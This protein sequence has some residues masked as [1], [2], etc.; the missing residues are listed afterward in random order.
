MAVMILKVRYDVM[1]YIDVARKKFLERIQKRY[2]SNYRT[3][4]K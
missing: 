1:Q 4:Q 2:R 3:S